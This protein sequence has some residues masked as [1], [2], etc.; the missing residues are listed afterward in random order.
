[1]VSETPGNDQPQGRGSRPAAS[2]CVPNGRAVVQREEWA[3]QLAGVYFSKMF[4]RL[5]LA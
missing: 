1:V 5:L 2:G 4:A 3:H